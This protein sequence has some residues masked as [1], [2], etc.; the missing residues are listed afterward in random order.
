MD[1]D[2]A[3][4][5]SSAEPHERRH[6]LIRAHRRKLNKRQIAREAGLS[7]SATC[8]IIDRFTVG[9]MGALA[10]RVRGRGTGDKRVLTPR[11]EVVIQRMICGKRPEQ[12]KMEFALWNRAAVQELILRTRG[13]GRHVHPVGKYLARWGFPPQ[14]SIRRRPPAIG[15]SLSM[16]ASR[17]PIPQAR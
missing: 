5:L 14:K 9:G 3:R 4:R 15:D 11:Q 16:A 17:W 1:T 10:P 13:I 7:Y 2:D 8:Q 12:L 6:Q